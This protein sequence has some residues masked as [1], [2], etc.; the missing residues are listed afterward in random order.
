MSQNVRPYKVREAAEYLVTPGKLFKDQ[1][2]SFDKTWAE[3]D[4]LSNNID[5]NERSSLQID[6]D[7]GEPHIVGRAIFNDI[8]GEPQTG[9]SNWIDSLNPA[10]RE[11]QIECGTMIGVGEPQPGCSRWND[12]LNDAIREAQMEFGAATES[13]TKSDDRN[14][15]EGVVEFRVIAREVE[16]GACLL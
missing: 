4:E 2:I 11:G 3:N 15:T 13:A 9:C 6:T 8:A 1:G 5:V 12:S 16:E 10:V 14:E 7:I